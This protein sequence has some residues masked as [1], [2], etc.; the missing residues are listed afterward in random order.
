MSS[1]RSLIF[2]ALAWLAAIACAAL[3]DLRVAH[4]VRDSG[5]QQWMAS[6][7]LVGEIIKSPGSFIFTLAVAPAVMFLHP[8]R[9]RAGGFL[10]LATIVSGINGLLKWV[11]GRTRPFK[12][13]VYDLTG[14]PLAA[15]FVLSPFRGGIAGLLVGKNLCFPSGHAALAFA[16]AAALAM[17]WPRS[18]WRWGGY[19]LASAVAA[20]RVAENA[21]WLSDCVAAAALG[22]G[23]VHLIHWAVTR[24]FFREEED[25]RSV[26]PRP[27][28]AS[29]AAPASET[30]MR[31]ATVNESSVP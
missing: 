18:P 13:A 25:R 17:L 19:A 30:A 26:G 16:T 24:L 14:E 4:W 6:H 28:G 23:G 20:E 22:V 3:L 12:L 8:L 21:H 9:W 29:E 1:R 2:S 5:L 7:R 31:R 10:L 11:A 15:P 27:S